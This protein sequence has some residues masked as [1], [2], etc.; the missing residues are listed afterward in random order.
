M[1]WI[2]LAPSVVAAFVSRHSTPLL[3]IGIVNVIVSFYAINTILNLGTQQDTGT[4]MDSFERYKSVSV[5]VL[6]LSW[7]VAIV[8]IVL[9]IV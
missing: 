9:A 2:A 4:E 8:L 5:G 6:T 1:P 7:V 3:I